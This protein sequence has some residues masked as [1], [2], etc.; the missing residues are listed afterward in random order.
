VVDKARNYKDK[1]YGAFGVEFY[2]AKKSDFDAVNKRV[3]FDESV[4]YL[5]LDRGE[6]SLVSWCLVDS[7]GKLI[8]NGDW[9]T[10]LNSVFM[11]VDYAE[12]LNFTKDEHGK[13]EKSGF[14]KARIV[15]QEKYQK[16][17]DCKNEEE[18][19]ILLEEAKKCEKQFDRDGLLAAEQI[20]KGYCGYLINKINRI[21][22]EY[23]H[24]YIVLED[25]DI[26]G[27][28]KEDEDSTNKIENLEKTLGGT[29]YQAVENA[30][31]NK[32]KYYT[33]KDESGYDGLQLVPNIVRVEDLR[34]S[35]NRENSQSGKVKWVKSKEK[36]GNI[37]FVDEFLTSQM[38]PKCG[39]C[40][41][42]EEEKKR[43]PRFAVPII[44]E[45]LQKDFQLNLEIEDGQEI[46]I[47]R[48]GNK[49]LK[50]KHLCALK[51]ARLENIKIAV[52]EKR[53]NSNIKNLLVP[54][55]KSRG[56]DLY[57]YDYLKRD[58]VYCSACGFNTEEPEKFGL[59][60]KS[61][62]DAAAYNIA[63]IGLE[64]YQAMT[65]KKP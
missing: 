46:M 7:N 21:L 59:P 10:M 42:S 44:E 57:E 51:S 43:L 17:S 23:P 41:C 3:M 48:T 9:T 8:K 62:D 15:L 61:G 37:L 2:P 13:K 14:H 63:K 36:I 35:D 19:R 11:G 6:N 53:L 24:T 40:I 31:V 18:K 12:K 33:V 20:K 64:V 39:F 58:A 60:I 27:K 32:F 28:V 56:G 25:L 49:T 47:L 55:L 4:H 50:I 16:V 65:L 45:E 54:R 22:K 26:K 52:R 1:L 5:G 29:V 30:I 34:E 38:C